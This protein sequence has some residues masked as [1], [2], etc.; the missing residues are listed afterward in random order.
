MTIRTA[1]DLEGGQKLPDTHGAMFQITCERPW[2]VARFTRPQ[3]M[4]SWSLNRPGFVQA[5][6]VA[7]LEVGNE[8]LRHAPDPV[9]WFAAR[10]AARGLADAVGL[11]T[12]RDVS[13]YERQSAAVEDVRADCVVTLGLNN[14]ERVGQRV[15]AHLHPL[16]AG[17]INILCAVSEPLTEAAL[18]EAASLVT[19]A[20]TV[21]LS[22]VRY[23]RP[24]RTEAVTGT[25]T[26]CIV[27][28]APAGSPR[29]SFAGMHT[30]I[31]EVIG[32]CVLRATLA[33]A[34]NWCA[35]APPDRFP[36]RSDGDGRHAV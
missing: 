35:E 26:D 20:R 2:L 30:A 27:V 19:Q 32:A 34:A 3:T 1:D 31:G 9:A 10:L 29:T 12:A 22:Q 33:A 36:R 8:E 4:V 23:R 7:W 16:N 24:G 17:T 11:M 28:S 13:R 21:A 6:Q 14:G 5:E 25:G 18:L 15:G